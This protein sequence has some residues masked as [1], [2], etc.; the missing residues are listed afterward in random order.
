MD[1]YISESSKPLQNKWPEP[2]QKKRKLLRCS[3][4]LPPIAPVWTFPYLS[5]LDAVFA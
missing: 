1:D 5:I 2:L 4:N 3:L